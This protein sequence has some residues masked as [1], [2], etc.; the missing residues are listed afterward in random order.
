MS[1][2]RVSLLGHAAG[3]AWLSI[4]LSV[5]NPPESNK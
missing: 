1:Q 5:A 2:G 3:S 4:D